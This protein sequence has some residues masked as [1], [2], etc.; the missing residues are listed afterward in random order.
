[1][2]VYRPTILFVL[3]A[4]PLISAGTTYIDDSAWTFDTASTWCAASS[5]A[6]TC[7]RSGVDPLEGGDGQKIDLR[8][9]YGGTYHSGQAPSS[10]KFTFRGN[11]IAVYGIQ[12]NET[13]SGSEPGAGLWYNFPLCN[14]TGLD[15]STDSTLV[16]HLANE[17]PTDGANSMV[18]DYAVITTSD[19]QTQS[20]TIVGGVIGSVILS[21]LIL[22]IFWWRRRPS[23]MVSD[24]IYVDD[25][26]EPTLP[27]SPIQLDLEIESPS[28]TNDPLSPTR[29]SVAT[30]VYQKQMPQSSAAPNEMTYASG[31]AST[32]SRLAL[33]E[34][35][36]AL[37]R[38]SSTNLPP[39]YH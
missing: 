1:M 12:I 16:L 15:E 20:G 3:T 6:A 23:R 9:T 22:G 4:I 25:I 36:I 31:S 14:I 24:P 8:K 13:Y 7:L 32:A 37:L 18:F 29:S 27:F 11:G 39:S 34:E 35:G 2:Q 10:A 30:A 17:S 38:G 21:V 26:S 19:P 28:F 33:L 5:Q